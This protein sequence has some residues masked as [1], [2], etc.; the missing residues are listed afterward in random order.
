MG[1]GAERNLAM[2][3]MVDMYALGFLNWSIEQ[4]RF[5]VI[6]PTTFR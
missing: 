5:L 1:H 2:V 3:F 6:I 4:Q